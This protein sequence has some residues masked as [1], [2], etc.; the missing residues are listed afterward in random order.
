[1][2]TIRIIIKKDGNI[3]LDF[4]GFIGNECYISRD[5]LL[6]ILKKL[7]VDNKIVIDVPK[8]EAKIV[9]KTYITSTV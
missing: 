7:G 3:E 2:K 1:M 9:E 8:P 6:E 4:N 5:K